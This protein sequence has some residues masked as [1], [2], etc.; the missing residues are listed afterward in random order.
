MKGRPLMALF[1]RYW[2][3][4]ERGGM[5][6]DRRPEMRDAFLAGALSALTR[7]AQDGPDVAWREARRASLAEHVAELAPAHGIEPIDPPPPR[8]ICS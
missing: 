6:P 1:A 4:V 2:R 3:E 7:A 5:K 8:G